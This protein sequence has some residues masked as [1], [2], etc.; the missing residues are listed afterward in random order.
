MVHYRQTSARHGWIILWPL[1]LDPDICNIT[2]SGRTMTG[3]AL[4]LTLHHWPPTHAIKYPQVLGAS[5]P[6][7]TV[8]A[9]VS[10]SNR[11]LNA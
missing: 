10:T 6:A 11:D 4:A 3:E 2:P 9:S 1:L 5:T 8:I 7:N